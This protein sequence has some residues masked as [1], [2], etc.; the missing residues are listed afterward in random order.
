MTIKTIYFDYGGVIYKTPSMEG[1]NRWTQILGLSDEPEIAEMLENPN[2]SQF[3]KDMCLGKIP[4][5][6]VW[7][8]MADKWHIKP[9]LIRRVRRALVS[10]RRLNKPIV[11]LMAELSNQYRTAILSNAGD[12]TRQLMEDVF[13]LDQFVDEIIISA[14]EG[15]IKPDPQIYMIAMERMN[16]VPESS[17]FI[18]DYLEN[19][20]AA[21]EFGM[22]AVHFIDNAQAIMAVRGY[23]AEEV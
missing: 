22:K 4:E 6:R 10:K 2:E 20:L 15:V 17:L 1:L 12:Q 16:A 7:T 11:N 3:V 8:I 19:V 5:D 13:H 9:S 23:L 21:R 18:D 14:E